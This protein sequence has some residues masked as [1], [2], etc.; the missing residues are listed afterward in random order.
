MINTPKPSAPSMT[1]TIKVVGYETFD[2]LTT[3]FDTETRTFDQMGTTMTNTAR[4][5]S[6]MTNTPKP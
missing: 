4:V 5:T 1:N 2:T 3:T 6:T